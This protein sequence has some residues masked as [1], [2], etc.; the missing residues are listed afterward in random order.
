MACCFTHNLFAESGAIMLT[1]TVTLTDTTGDVAGRLGVPR[2]QDLWRD[3]DLGLLSFWRF[4]RSPGVHVCRSGLFGLR[5]AFMK[6]AG[7]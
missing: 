7:R 6:R 2:L 3:L 4:T 1:L 5:P